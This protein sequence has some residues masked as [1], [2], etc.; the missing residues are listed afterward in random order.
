MWIFRNDVKR[1]NRRRLSEFAK[2]I[3]L[4][5]DGGD[6]AGAEGGT[7]AE[8]GAESASAPDSFN[9]KAEMYEMSEKEALKF[10]V[11]KLKDMAKA[12]GCL[13]L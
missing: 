5:N 8:G 12:S 2:K 3:A 1:E 6:D 10:C 9:I 13:S 11:D 7:G 4:R